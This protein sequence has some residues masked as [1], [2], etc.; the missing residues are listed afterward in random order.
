[1]GLFDENAF[2]RD[3]HLRPDRAFRQMMDEYRDRVFL[4]CRRVTKD[5]MDAEDLAQEVFVRAWKGL[6]R[7]RGES[8]LTTWIYRIAWNVCATHLSQKGK[9]PELT[10]YSETEEDDD[11]PQGVHLGEEDHQVTGF[12]N[13]QFLS[14][15]F[16]RLPASQ[17]LVLTL[18]YLQG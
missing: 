14:T 15:L 11:K 2:L 1:M 18:Y 9:G 16:N 5:A 17:R 8:S 4:F 6:P 13:Q 12:E 7:F 10:P 3:Y